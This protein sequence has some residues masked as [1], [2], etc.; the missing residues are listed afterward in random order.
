MFK[1]EICRM[2]ATVFDCGTD[3][4]RIGTLGKALAFFAALVSLTSGAAPADPGWP[5]AF[6][7]GNQELTVHQPQVEYWNGFT[8]RQLRC[9]IAVKGVTP[10]EKFGT[11]EVDA[12][13]VADQP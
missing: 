2:K 4:R 8:N 3:P 11:V 6:R 13:T 7:S 9:A 12:T 10:Q 1:Q 5:R